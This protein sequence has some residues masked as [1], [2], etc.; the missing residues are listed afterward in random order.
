M[1]ALSKI[2][3]LLITLLAVSSLFFTVG[4]VKQNPPETIYDTPSV[5]I[6]D[7]VY[8]PKYNNY[9]GITLDG[10]I[11]EDIW[12]NQNKFIGSLEVGGVMHDFETSS[13]Y[14]EEGFVVYFK[15][16]GAAVYF[17]PYRVANQTS[18][19]ELYFAKGSMTDIKEGSFEV[20][21]D[22][23][24]AQDSKKY[25]SPGTLG[26]GYHNFYIFVDR[27][28]TIDGELNKPTNNGFCMEVMFPWEH[29]TEDG[30]PCETVCLDAA[31][32]NVNSETGG[33]NAWVSTSKTFFPGYK[34]ENPQTWHRFSSAG[35][36]NENSQ[37]LVNIN[38]GEELQ[39][40]TVEVTGTFGSGVSVRALPEAG[41]MVDEFIINGVSYD[42]P[43]VT[44]DS[45]AI[46]SL[47]IKISF[48]QVEGELRSFKLKAGYPGGVYE[49]VTDGEAIAL[50]DGDGNNYSGVVQ[51]GEVLITLPDGS[52]VVKTQSYGETTIDV[53]QGL[54][55]YD[56]LL[57]KKL[58][59]RYDDHLVVHDAAISGQTFG[60]NEIG[61]KINSYA[62]GER[63]AFDIDFSKPV[64]MDYTLKIQVGREIFASLRFKKSSGEME[65]AFFNFGSWSS[66]QKI[67]IKNINQEVKTYDATV[68]EEVNEAGNY[69]LKINLYQI[70]DGKTVT[71][72]EKANGK[73]KYISS[74]NVNGTPSE[75]VVIITD[76]KG[77]VWFENFKVVTGDAISKYSSADVLVSSSGD[78]NVTISKEK[79]GLGEKVEVLA[80]PKSADVGEN[81]ITKITVNGNEV[82]FTLDKGVAK[83][84][85]SHLDANIDAYDVK[86]YTKNVRY[87]D[88]TINVVGKAFDGSSLSLAGKKVTLQGLINTEFNIGSG[89]NVVSLVSSDY[90]VNIEG[91]LPATILVEDDTTSV[92]VVLAED[93]VDYFEKDFKLS[94]SEENGYTLT[95]SDYYSRVHF[96]RNIPLSN[97][98]K[99]S[100]TYNGSIAADVKQWVEFTFIASN[101]SQLKA[102]ILTWGTSFVFKNPLFTS[103]ATN[104]SGYSG[105]ISKNFYLI[106][107][108]GVL[109]LYDGDN[110]TVLATV[111]TASEPGVM[112]NLQEFFVHY[113]F[114]NTDPWSLTNF[115]IEDLS[116]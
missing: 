43:L 88:V 84:S 46:F 6:D 25:L 47:D 31:I 110:D 55:E 61:F 36:V 98:L 30:K 79:I 96:N 2:K 106:Y 101:G 35:Y 67:I 104:I 26:Y 10:N 48:K 72:Y 90:I 109:S 71:L 59:K 111:S 38:D 34:W 95:S 116:E 115:T 108:A 93:I 70:Y 53:S 81:V 51:S 40:G 87:K 22:V 60:F 39:N 13:Y 100:F 82:D 21:I 17:N 52:Y 49:A 41:Y 114:D 19:L 77:E 68:A 80:T 63:G 105:Q 45:K 83:L 99:I 33:R 66:N 3:I 5:T 73:L 65:T 57:N 89:D 113:A 92:D 97:N 28:V 42:Y 86:V 11:D 103:E 58:F 102:Q 85:I 7:Y 23:G 56:I 1:K 14:A 9:S 50:V 91:F 20:P 76:N 4:C 44:F 15:V 74:Y 16:T 94:Y 8:T 107:N 54:D 29:L 37:P 32:I 69:F 75:M 12:Q 24:G 27:A 62:D 112:T 64:V 78:S 18:G